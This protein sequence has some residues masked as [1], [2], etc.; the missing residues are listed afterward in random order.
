[1]AKQKEVIR[2]LQMWQDQYSIPLSFFF[3]IQILCY[4][5]ENTLFFSEI[6]GYYMDKYY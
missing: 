5:T 4:A 2:F 6:V 1:M 3:A